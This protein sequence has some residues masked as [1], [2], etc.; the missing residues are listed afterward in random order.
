MKGKEPISGE[1]MTKKT[2]AV[3]C[4]YNEAGATLPGIRFAP[5]RPRQPL[6]LLMAWPV[7]FPLAPAL[8]LFL[9]RQSKCEV[10][11]QSERQKKAIYIKR[12]IVYLYML[13]HTHALPR[14]NPPVRAASTGVCLLRPASL[15]SSII[16]TD[17]NYKTQA[18]FFRKRGR[19]RREA[20]T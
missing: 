4:I 12:C 19:V 17:S 3:V 6:L 11:R 10:E 5:A 14:D 9:H 15:A 13:T 8:P 2:D 1:D 7:L 18:E 16:A 20:L